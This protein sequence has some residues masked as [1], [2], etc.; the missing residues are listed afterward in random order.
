MINNFHNKLYI[1]IIYLERSPDIDRV[2]YKNGQN[3]I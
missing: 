1:F 3:K 2:K